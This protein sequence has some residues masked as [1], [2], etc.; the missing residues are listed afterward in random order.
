VNLTTFDGGAYSGY[1]NAAISFGGAVGGGSRLW[2]DNVQ[3]GTPTPEPS[4][5]ILSGLGLVGLVIA[6]R[7][8]K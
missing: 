8:R 5:W 7:R 3:I 1:S 6:A 2:T 4:T